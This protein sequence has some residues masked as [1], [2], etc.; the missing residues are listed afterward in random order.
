MYIECKSDTRDVAKKGA[1][2]VAVDLEKEWFRPLETGLKKP[3]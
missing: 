3:E 1:D 2:E